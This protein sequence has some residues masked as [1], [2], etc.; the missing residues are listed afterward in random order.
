MPCRSALAALLVSLVL[1]LAAQADECPYPQPVILAGLNW[2][3]GMFTTEVL[4][5]LLERGYGCKTDV[6]PGNTLAMENAL[7]Q[8]DVQVIAEQWAGR[9]E[10]WRKAEAAG[11]VFAVGEPVKGATEGWWVP[12]YLVKGEGAPAAGLRSVSDLPRFKTLFRDPEEDDKGRFYNC[13]TGWTCEGVNSQKLKAYGLEDSYVNFRTGTGPALDAA[14]TS[15]IRQRQP[16]LFYYWSPTPLMGRYPLVQLEEPPFDQKAWETLIDP[17][18]PKP[19]GSRSLPAKISIGVSRDLRERAPQLVEAFGKMEIPLSLFNR[20]LAEM[21]EQ[22]SEARIVSETFYR[23]HRDIWSRWVP[24][25]VAQ[26]I[27]ASLR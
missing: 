26:R 10:L 23:E 6:L 22:R 17:N 24:E 9:S 16:I 21:A 1:P 3:S 12:E 27:D 5:Y 13:P 18:N 4:R 11:E 25:P 8:N 14:I 7:R 19:I 15:A 2:E 20:I